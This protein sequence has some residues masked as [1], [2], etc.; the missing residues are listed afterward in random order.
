MY[1]QHFGFSST[2]FPDGMAQDDAIFKTSASEKILTDI[3]IALSRKDSVAIFSGPSGTGKTTI[4]AD[5]LQ[6]IS[7]RLAYTCIN[8]PPLRPDEL[9]ERLLTDFD[10]ETANQSRVQRLQLWRQFLSE[11]TATDTRVCL[12]FE[13]A[14][15]LEQE[16]LQFLH[17]LTA[18]DPAMCAGANVV[19]TTR[20]PP[21]CLLA[22]EEM[23]PFNQ[24]VRLRRHIKP[25]T[26]DETQTYLAFLCD[27]ANVN[28]ENVFA[29]D[30]VPQLYELSRGVVRVIENLLESALMSA[31]AANETTVSA[32]RL[33]QVAED[34]FGL[35]Q[36]GPEDVVDLIEKPEEDTEPSLFILN[37]D[38]VPTLT[39]FVSVPGPAKPVETPEPAE[40]AIYK[41]SE[42]APAYLAYGSPKH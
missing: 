37:E 18:A 36:M 33:S 5:A 32:E 35:M 6:H 17:Q 27:R 8:Y 10:L 11:T 25:L 34:Q 14:E 30:L 39:D 13:N 24:R 19:L 1:E 7:T 15:N 20:Q 31:A 29:T 16:V 42:S 12:L 40:A 26:E 28:V 23:R 9:L 21:E 4:A 3:E 2:L 41:Q 38:G 22:T